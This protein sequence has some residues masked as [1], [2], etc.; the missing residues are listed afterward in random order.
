MNV[1]WEVIRKWKWIPT[2]QFNIGKWEIF[3]NDWKVAHTY[4]GNMPHIVYENANKTME[5]K[6]RGLGKIFHWR[7]CRG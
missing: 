2:F 5:R 1:T 6:D 7:V 4:N 3:V